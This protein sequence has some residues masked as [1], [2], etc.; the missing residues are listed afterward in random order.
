MPRSTNLLIT[1]TRSQSPCW[2]HRCSWSEGKIVQFPPNER[3]ETIPVTRFFL[4]LNW[5]F[6]WKCFWS[7]KREIAN[8]FLGYIFLFIVH[9]NYH[10]QFSS[11]RRS[12][13]RIAVV[14]IR[15][16][17][18]IVRNTKDCLRKGNLVS[19][20]FFTEIPGKELS[21][22]DKKTKERLEGK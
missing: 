7:P 3:K 18:C 5:Y 8:R 17:M 16:Q 20:S 21:F 13:R 22:L 2:A 4:Y 11:A 19:F 1:R 14:S 9:V 15:P 6:P 12:N 10:R